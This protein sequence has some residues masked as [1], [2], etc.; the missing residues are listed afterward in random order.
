MNSIELTIIIP[1]YNVEKYISECLES[2]LSNNSNK[3]EFLIIND[4]ST[5]KSH[6]IAKKLTRHD[7]RVFI[8]EKKNGGLSDARNMGLDFANGR[9]VTFIDSD[10]MVEKNY[11]QNVISVIESTDN[12]LI[13]TSRYFFKN[14]RKINNFKILSTKNIEFEDFLNRIITWNNMDFS[15]CN[16]IF[17][18]NLI[19]DIRFEKDK[20]CEDMGFFIKYY[21]KISKILLL[22]GPS[23]LYRINNDSI[24]NKPFYSK[25]FDLFIYVEEIYK[26]LYNKVNYKF[27]KKFRLTNHVYL[28]Y[29]II[30]S[31]NSENH[32]DKFK[33]IMS[34]VKKELKYF[35]L[36]SFRKF[37]QLMYIIVHDKIK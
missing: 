26:L 31:K 32:Y 36:L 23:Y 27:L 13:C 28:A 11:F 2:L 17:K 22:K 25:R 9:Y 1:L 14:G 29:N 35:Y 3:L 34:I 6:E 33:I 24:S 4:G 18:R 16:K 10:D 7:K 15:V 21:S 8:Y 37:V 20:I 12:D 30:V 19:L 5:D